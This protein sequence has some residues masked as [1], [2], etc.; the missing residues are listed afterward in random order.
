MSQQKTPLE[1]VGW[2]SGGGHTIAINE[3]ERQRAMSQRNVDE[4]RREL[5][6]ALENPVGQYIAPV[7][8][9]HLRTVLDA[10][11]ARDADVAALRE[12]LSGL[13]DG[14]AI[15]KTFC[16]LKTREKHSPPPTQAR[17]CWMSTIS[18]LL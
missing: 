2:L 13:F 9:A 10:L 4:I 8:K 1:V 7:E 15:K 16:R 17:G 3:K 18:C 6:R 12:S 5:R 14:L 11:D